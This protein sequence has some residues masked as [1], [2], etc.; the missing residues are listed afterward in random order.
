MK[1]VPW[2][3]GCLIT[4]DGGGGGDDG[5]NDSTR[6]PL[7]VIQ[8]VLPVASSAAKP[9][10]ILSVLT[11]TVACHV[12]AGPDGARGTKCQA[13]PVVKNAFTRI[14]PAVALSVTVAK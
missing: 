6:R 2:S 4:I 5:V 7:P 11:G 14:T 1:Y 9:T 13:P 8:P 3:S 10:S 12:F